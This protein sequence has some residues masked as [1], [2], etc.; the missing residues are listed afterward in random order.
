[1]NQNYLNYISNFNETRD[2]AYEELTEI[3]FKESI[4]QPIK[5][6]K[7]EFEHTTNADNFHWLYYVKNKQ[8][9]RKLHNVNKNN[10]FIIYDKININE[11]NEDVKNSPKVKSNLPPKK[12]FEID[13]DYFDFDEEF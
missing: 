5:R 6:D 8:F 10:T 3:K 7:R 13:N 4:T 12:M 9:Y 2:K 1:M 11:T